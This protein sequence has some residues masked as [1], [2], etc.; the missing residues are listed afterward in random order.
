MI[1]NK[2]PFLL[3][4]LA[5]TLSCCKVIIDY[6]Y[7]VRGTVFYINESA[8]TVVSLDSRGGCEK[9][10]I[11]P[12]DTLVY[13][14]SGIIRSRQDINTNIDNFPY[15]VFTCGEMLYKDGSVL[16]VEEEIK[17]LKNYE[18]RKEISPGVFEFTF[19]FTEEKK[20]KAPLVPC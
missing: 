7:K 20:A 10:L 16:R 13:G 8:D 3:I 14:F 2:I 11:P 1:I 5:V 17:D 18:N 4:V 6:S 15:Y 12:N 9:K 19:R